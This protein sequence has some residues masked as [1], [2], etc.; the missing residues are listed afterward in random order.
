M[1]L[2]MPKYCK[3]FRCIADKCKD[4]C[5]I[6]WEIDIDRE[7]AEY[8]NKVVGDLGKRLKECIK[9]EGDVSSFILKGERCPFLNKRNLCDIIINEGEEHLCQICTD[10]PRYYE[11]FN[12]LKE[13]GIGLCCEEAA[14]IVLSQT[15]PLSFWDREL[16][17]E[18]CDEY[19]A[20][21]YH[22]LTECRE[23]IIHLFEDKSVSL[24]NCISALIDFANNI[25]NRIDICDYTVPPLNTQLPPLNADITEILRHLLSLEAMDEKWKPYIE[26]VISN[27][28]LDS[29]KPFSSADTEQYLRNIAVY[30]I[31]RYFMKAVFDEDVIP[32]ISLT[33]ISITVIAYLFE[34]NRTADGI[35]TL[36]SCAETAKAYSKEIEYSPENCEAVQFYMN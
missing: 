7:T 3:N 23:M 5:C 21:L 22:Y 19:D 16:A 32:Q 26:E 35:L 12:G 20:G 27:P 14:R 31:W 1:I 28:E 34:H 9:T 30:F 11:W 6:G 17:D 29:L 13:G 33:A 2:R 36:E 25:Q 8:Y 18:D 15:S 24:E 10:H 4:N